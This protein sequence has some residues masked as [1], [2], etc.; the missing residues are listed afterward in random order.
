MSEY[1]RYHGWRRRLWDG[2][3]GGEREKRGSGVTKT[4]QH[5]IMSV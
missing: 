1:R 5:C 4:L 2:E 3:G